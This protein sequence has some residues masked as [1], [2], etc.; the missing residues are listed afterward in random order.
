MVA[1]AENRKS[2]TFIKFVAYLQAIGILLV[3]FGHSFHEYPD[4]SMGKSLLIYRM[5]YSFRMPLFIFV[6]GFLMVYTNF[7]NGKETSW[8]SFTGSKIKRLLVPYFFLSLITFLPRVAMSSMADDKL[9][10]SLQSFVYA[11]FYGGEGMVIPLFWFLQASFLLLIITHLLISIGKKMNLSDGVIYTSL[12]VIAMMLLALPFNPSRFFSINEAIRLVLYFVLGAMYCRF[13]SKADEIVNWTSVPLLLIFGVLW[14]SS[15]FLTEGTAWNPICS[16]FGILMC[17]SIAKMMVKYGFTLLDSLI[18]ANYMIFL[19]SW[20]FNV[21][22]QQVLSHFVEMPWWCYT[23]I[24]FTS[25][26]YFPWLIY[27]MMLRNAG[28]KF[29]KVSAFLLGQ[30]LNKSR[31]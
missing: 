31:R 13:Q 10:L 16:V 4:G 2:T 7:L 18:G 3:V 9:E 12:V 25:A 28:N 21:V 27:R 17:I 29:V 8:F 1:S 23:V 6:S 15:F 20:Y 26:V 22:S 14:A 24:S 19:L 11:L 30:N 5:M